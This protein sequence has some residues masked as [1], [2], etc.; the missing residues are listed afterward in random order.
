MFFVYEETE[1]EE[2]TA[3]VAFEEESTADNP[4]NDKVCVQKLDDGS[5]AVEIFIPEAIGEAVSIL[6]LK[7]DAAVDTWKQTP[8]EIL[9]IDQITLDSEGKGYVILMMGEGNAEV[10]AVTYAGGIETVSVKQ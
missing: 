1:N 6:A 9:A 5:L 3:T 10:V 7:T 2:T 4:E 8:D